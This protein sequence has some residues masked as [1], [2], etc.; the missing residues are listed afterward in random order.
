MISFLSL[1]CLCTEQIF[2]SFRYGKY[3]NAFLSALTVVFQQPDN[4]S[5]AISVVQ[6]S[7]YEELLL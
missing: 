7:D 4:V 6:V 5:R 2:V 1:W 3:Y